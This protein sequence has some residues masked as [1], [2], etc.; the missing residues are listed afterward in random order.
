LF[1]FYFYLFYAAKKAGTVTYDFDV[2]AAKG[3]KNFR[4]WLPYPSSDAN[5]DIGEPKVTG[6]YQ[7]Y[8]VVD[9]AATKTKYLTAL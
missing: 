1:I 9:N 8:E 6:D 3:A 5:Q 7:S 4:L 2:A